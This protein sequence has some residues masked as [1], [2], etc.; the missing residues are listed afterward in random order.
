M[1]KVTDTAWS[2]ASIEQREEPLTGERKKSGSPASAASVGRVSPDVAR[3]ALRLS[4]GS[5]REMCIGEYHSPPFHCTMEP[6]FETAA[7]MLP[8]AS[9]TNVAVPS[10]SSK[11]ALVAGCVSNAIS[12]LARDLPSCRTSSLLHDAA[13]KTA[14]ATIIYDFPNSFILTEIMLSS[15]LEVFS[16]KQFRG[17]ADK[18]KI[19][20]RCVFKPVNV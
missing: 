11:W 3:K 10:R 4:S 15:I 14:S 8:S 20:I 19:C 17:G 6:P 1:E 9:H 5:I 18:Y 12:T 13:G 16:H 2:E 7:I